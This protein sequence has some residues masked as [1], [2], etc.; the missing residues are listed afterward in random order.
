MEEFKPYRRAQI[1]EL[2]D[3]HEGFDMARVSIS[4]VDRSNGSP[5]LGDK[6]ARNPENH[7]DRWLVAADYFAKNFVALTAQQEPVAESHCVWMQDSDGPWNTSCGHVFEFTDGGPHQNDAAWCQY[8]GG[9]LLPTYHDG[10]QES[11]ERNAAL[12]AAAKEPRK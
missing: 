10:E 4:D 9:K 2:A 1:A 12:L 8:C 7:E 6:I 11:V 5:K 3:W